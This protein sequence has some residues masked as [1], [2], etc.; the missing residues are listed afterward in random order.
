MA[1][2]IVVLLVK[3]NFCRHQKY[4][5]SKRPPFYCLNNSARHQ[6]IFIRFGTQHPEETSCER[7]QFCPPRLKTVTTLPRAR[8]VG[9]VDETRDRRHTVIVFDS[10]ELGHQTV[11][12]RYVLPSAGA[13]ARPPLAVRTLS[14]CW[15]LWQ[16]C[17]VPAPGSSE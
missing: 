7:F 17:P 6:P 16:T 8:C 10:A 1:L 13:V 15:L 5:V 12:S 14:L 3:N 4:A 2:L 11:A 9:V